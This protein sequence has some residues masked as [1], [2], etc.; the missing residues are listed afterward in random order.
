M[1]GKNPTG[2][3]QQ[4]RADQKSRIERSRKADNETIKLAA[5]QDIPPHAGAG[6]EEDFIDN[7]AFQKHARRVS[8]RN[9]RKRF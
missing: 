2:R 4:T 3:H 5:Q 1:A 8:N 9:K 6:G 7:E